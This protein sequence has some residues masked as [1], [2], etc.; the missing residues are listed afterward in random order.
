M[1]GRTI[2]PKPAA[3]AN[4]TCASGKPEAR[5]FFEP[6]KTAVISSARDRPSLRAPVMVKPIT[7]RSSTRHNA[8]A[9]SNPLIGS[10]CQSPAVAD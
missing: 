5:L 3:P 10:T 1:I 7:A 8:P 4:S 9:N 6:Q 2:M